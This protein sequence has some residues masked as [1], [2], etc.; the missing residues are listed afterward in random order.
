M[1]SP[2]LTS[3]TVDGTPG[4]YSLRELIRDVPLSTNDNGTRAHITCVD[5]WNGNLYI[6][7]SSGQVLHYVSIPPDPSSTDESGSPSYIFATTIEPAYRTRQEGPDEGVKQILLLPNASKACIVCNSTLTFYTLPELSPAYDGRIQQVGCRWVG[8]LDRNDLEDHHHAQQN[9]QA[10]AVMICLRQRLR[11]IG[12]GDAA[13]PTKI[14]DIELGGVSA[15]ERRGDLACVADASTYSLLD[16]V[17]QRKNDLFPIASSS[18]SQWSEPPPAPDRIAPLPLSARGPSRSF[19]SHSPVRAPR[20]HQRNISL[21]S[22]ALSNQARTPERLRP[23][24]SSPWPKRRSSRQL[25]SPLASRQPDSPLAP[26]SRDES[27]FQQAVDGAAS[28]SSTPQS[29]LQTQPQTTEGAETQ[30]PTLLPNILSPTPNEFLLTTGTKEDE[31]GV[32]MFVNLDGDVVRGT[33]EFA[34]Y[35]HSVILDQSNQ[36][37]PDAAID[38][39]SQEG[40]VLAIVQ[41]KTDN[42]LQ[43]CI[44]FQRWNADDPS[45][46]QRTKEYL[47]LDTGAEES[48]SKTNVTSRSF[49]LRNAVSPANLSAKEITNSLRMRR[50]IM[51]DQDASQTTSD[52]DHKRNLEEDSLASRFAQTHTNI[53]LYTQ[54]RVSWIVRTPLLAQLDSQLNA[55]ILQTASTKTLEIDVPVVQRVV[56]SIR[57]QDP[58]NELEFLTLTYIRQ[59]SAVLLFGN[60]VLQTARGVIAYEHDKRRAEDAL[61]E[62]ELDPRV[63]LTLVPPFEDEIQEG[64]HGVW[65]PQGIRDTIN[66]IRQNLKFEE[67]FRDPRGPYTDNLL[68]VLKRYLVLWREK[69]GFGS[70]ADEAHVFHTVDAAL[71]H[72]LLFLDQNSPRG[73]AVA[74]SLRA[75]INEVVDRGL[76]CEFE[77]A[78][79]LFERFKRLYLLSRFYQ[80]RKLV[81]GVL[82]C[83][84]RI[85]EGE[86]DFGG[87]FDGDG[88]GVLR[89]YLSRI[90]DWGIVREY[91]AWLARR[92]PGLGVQVFADDTSRVRF[93]AEEALGILKK[94]A[95]GAVRYFLEDL[96]FGKGN[97]RYVNDLIA[98]YLD[99]VIKELEDED[100]DARRILLDSYA[101]YRG[102]RGPKPTYWEFMQENGVEEDWWDMRLGLLRLIG[103]SGGSREGGFSEVKFGGLRGRLEGFGDV[104]VPEMILLHGREGRHGEALRLLVHGLGDYDS[105]IRY[106]LRGGEGIFF[107]G[108]EVGVEGP[109]KEEQ[110]VLFGVLLD[111][112][113]LIGDL[114]ERVERCVE[115]LERFGGWFDVEGVLGRI[116]DDWSVELVSGFL[117]MALRM[118]VRERNETVVVKALCSARNLR[119][120]VEF[121]E[122]CEGFGGRVVGAEV[123]GD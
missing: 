97:G 38:D 120:N 63:I 78:V 26:S 81:G 64:S 101:R 67:I 20:G 49:G 87:E 2:A 30:Q 10:T 77:R 94:D 88:E 60:L 6:G 104:L 40:Y 29:H 119:G 113:F 24:D 5:A 68:G 80:S 115:L 27:P 22:Q 66:H 46:A 100:S 9:S 96:V 110:G 84:R 109:S 112:F 42:G 56:N 106:C 7:T 61:I 99:G 89:R 50:L 15:L 32:G 11:L 54:D 114:G 37:S 25:D 39:P 13:A 83:W 102:L 51:K 41:R 17:N 82:G 23:D 44:E 47:V 79:E 117:I 69:K 35:P 122:M 103:T 65:M 21:G 16:V 108:G 116:P 95:P 34:S 59:K 76:D 74:G 73:Q 43:R 90:R 111:E 52:A 33:I 86:G 93:E 36:S 91:G 19:S 12:V 72:L 105:A 14:R 107:P 118:L 62:G 18:S 3:L 28:S 123:V 48:D 70:V 55:A 85:L 1:E 45:E 53:L 121:A 8:G 58:L 75:E 57:G 4:S 71:L 98:F 92:N 31:P